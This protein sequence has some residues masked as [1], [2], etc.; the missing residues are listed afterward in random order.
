MGKVEDSFDDAE[1]S[2]PYSTQ[3][4]SPQES[5]GRNIYIKTASF[6]ELPKAEQ[7][8]YLQALWDQ[9]SEHPDEIPVPERV[10]LNLPKNAYGAI[11]NTLPRHGPLLKLS[12]ACHRTTSEAI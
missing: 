11:A 4:S 5:D 9:I 7:V 1:H 8:R 2:R 3:F 10:I 6:A 12:T